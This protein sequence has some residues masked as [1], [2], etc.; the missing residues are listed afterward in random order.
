VL[1]EDRVRAGSFGADAEQ[2][3]RSRPTY[4]PELIDDLL[5]DLPVAGHASVLDVGVGTGI[6]S[7]LFLARGCSVVGVE[8]DE[9]MAVLARRYGIRVEPGTFEEWVRNERKFDVV[10]S[11]QAWHWVDPARGAAKAATA[12]RSGGHIGLFWNQGLHRPPLKESLEH[13]YRLIA[14]GLDG[15]SIALGKIDDDRFDRTAQSLRATGAFD[16]IEV[17]TYS[18]SRTYTTGQWLDQ[19]PTHSDHRALSPERLALLLGEVG[20]TV[21]GVGG[22]FEMD[23]RTWL[24]TATRSATDAPSP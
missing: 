9:R 21:D 16:R 1:H 5:A 10:V 7:R 3:D 24:V 12:L 18:W 8:P 15:Y 4:P 11:G 6:V 23:Y 22:T 19:L 20:R 13:A 2:Y 14:P 17:R